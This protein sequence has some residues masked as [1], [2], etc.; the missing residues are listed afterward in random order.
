MYASK[1]GQIFSP[2]KAVHTCKCI[3][4]S[5]ESLY[6][7]GCGYVLIVWRNGICRRKL[8]HF[9]RQKRGQVEL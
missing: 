6:L 1:L 7:N 2:I 9:W 4:A 8:A 3:Q 5:M